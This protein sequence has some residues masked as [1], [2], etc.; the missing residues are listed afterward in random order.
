M[1]IKGVC[2]AEKFTDVRKMEKDIQIE[3]TLTLNGP[4]ERQVIRFIKIFL[5]LHSLIEFYL[6]AFDSIF[7]IRILSLLKINRF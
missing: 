4:V 7:M 5:L 1:E 2:Y 3:E 6:K